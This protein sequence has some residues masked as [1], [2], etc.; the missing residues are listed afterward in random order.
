MGNSIT[1]C[2][3]ELEKE[4]VP[5]IGTNCTLNSAEM[6]EVINIFRENTSLRSLPRPMQ[7]NRPFQSMGTSLILKA[8]K[9]M[10]TIFL[11]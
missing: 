1:Q 8:W 4:N 6:V 9:I 10:F 11:R 7:E 5:A 2:I 3:E